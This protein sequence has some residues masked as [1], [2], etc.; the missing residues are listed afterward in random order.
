M[1]WSISIRGKETNMQIKEMIY[2]LN[3]VKNC[4]NNKKDCNHD[5]MHCG[6]HISNSTVCETIDRVSNLLENISH[7]STR[8]NF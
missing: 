5:C 3:N 4:I 7:K 2:V 6:F 8:Q 1:Q